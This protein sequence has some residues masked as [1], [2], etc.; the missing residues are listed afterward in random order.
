MTTWKRVFPMQIP[1]Q[2]VA[3]PQKLDSSNL[4]SQTLSIMSEKTSLPPSLAGADC[5]V[6]ATEYL[7]KTIDFAGE[8]VYNRVKAK[9]ILEA[10]ALQVEGQ[11]R[12]ESLLSDLGF[13]SCS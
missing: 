9:R 8:N 11:V 3:Q 10:L 7:D 6:R 5:L 1:V 4:P 2:R 12:L 13:S